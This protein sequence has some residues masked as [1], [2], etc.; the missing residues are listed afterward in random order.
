MLVACEMAGWVKT[1]G[2]Q[3]WLLEVA[4]SKAVQR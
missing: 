2:H 4:A 3:A 1:L